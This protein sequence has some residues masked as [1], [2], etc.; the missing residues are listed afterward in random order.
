MGQGIGHLVVV[1]ETKLNV[2]ILCVL[3][4]YI[5]TLVPR[6]QGMLNYVIGVH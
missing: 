6:Y 4:T 2:K 1:I 3:I 5:V